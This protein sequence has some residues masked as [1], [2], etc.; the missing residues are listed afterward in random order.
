[1]ESIAIA[2]T[3]VPGMQKAD[4]MTFRRSF[5]PEGFIFTLKICDGVA[6]RW[7]TLRPHLIANV[8]NAN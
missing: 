5:W 3:S 6:I 1:M 8:E 4:A 2:L 7:K